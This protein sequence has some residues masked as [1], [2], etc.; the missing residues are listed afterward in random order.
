MSD[1]RNIDEMLEVLSQ[2]LVRCVVIGIAALLFWWA[3]LAIM[4]DLAY[5]IHTHFLPMTRAHFNLMHYA[6]LLATKAAVA[7]LF[8]FPYIA[9]RLVL[10]KRKAPSAA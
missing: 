1:S 9:I 8:F 2:V 10:R 4:G 6:G 7:L 5:R 3:A